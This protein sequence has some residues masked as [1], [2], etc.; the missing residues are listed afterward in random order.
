[1]MRPKN[2]KIYVTTKILGKDLIR[3]REVVFKF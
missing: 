3:K 1:M 2:R